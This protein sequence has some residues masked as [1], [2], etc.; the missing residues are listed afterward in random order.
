GESQP[1]ILLLDIL[2]LRVEPTSPGNPFIQVVT[3][4][5]EFPSQAP[6]APPALRDQPEVFA[7]FLNDQATPFSIADD[8]RG[9]GEL[10]DDA[11]IPSFGEALLARVD[12]GFGAGD[13]EAEEN[14]EGPVKNPPEL[15]EKATLAQFITGLK[16]ALERL[17]R[18]ERTEAIP[19]DRSTTPW[20]ASNWQRWWE[21]L[22]QALAE[23]E[24]QS[25]QTPPAAGKAPDTPE[26]IESP[27]ELTPSPEAAVATLPAAASTAEQPAAGHASPSLAEEAVPAL[28]TLV[29]WIK[30]GSTLAAVLTGAA[31]AWVGHARRQRP[32][33]QRRGPEKAAT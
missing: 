16:E 8:V 24:R 28:P 12:V 5:T 19:G 14:T 26:M 15:E 3:A 6:S 17:G 30:R 10:P 27:P 31:F 32:L 25:N 33:R 7:P 22:G 20:G 13:E 29:G 2:D 21:G 18:E 1:V 4:I 11:V 9:L 23:I